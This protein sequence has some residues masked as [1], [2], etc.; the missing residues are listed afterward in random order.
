[1]SAAGGLALLVAV[2]TAAGLTAILLSLFLVVSAVGL[3]LPNATALA[4]A[5]YRSRAG[6]ASAVIGTLQYGL[7]GIV[8]PIVGIAGNT[9]ALPFALVIATCGSLA[10]L[11]CITL[12]RSSPLGVH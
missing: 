10:L 5:D 12:T 6:A 3:N 1:M 9:T 7:G 2:F 4:M 8:A 11:T